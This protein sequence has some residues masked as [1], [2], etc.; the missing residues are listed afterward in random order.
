[1]T[2]IVVHPQH[3]GG[4]YDPYEAVKVIEAWG[5]DWHLANALKYISRAGKKPGVSAIDDFRKSVWYLERHI[6]HCLADEPAC[7]GKG[8]VT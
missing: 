5:V 1:M 3:Y 8:R 4:E 7:Y 6:E 2:D